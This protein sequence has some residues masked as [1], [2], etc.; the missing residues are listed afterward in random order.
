MKNIGRLSLYIF[1]GSFIFIQFFRAEKNLSEAVLPHDFLE[2]NAN[3]PETLQA[4]FRTA[5]YDCHSNH[6]NYP[7]YAHIAPFSWIVEQH[8]RNGKG[9]MNLST[10]DTLSDR[11]KIAILDDI[12]EAVKIV[13]PL[14]TSR[15]KTMMTATETSPEVEQENET[16][17][18]NE[19][20]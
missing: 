17:N 19:T 16:E 12:Y 7:W 5:C 2:V 1:L 14:L 4:T 8:I 10:Y 11:Q 6:T 15:L 20:T 3:M 18:E 13:N 9:E